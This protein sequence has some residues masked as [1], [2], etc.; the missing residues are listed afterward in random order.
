MPQHKPP[1]WLTGSLK[2]P[3]LIRKNLCLPCLFLFF[4]P[5]LA[6]LWEW[7]GEGDGWGVGPWGARSV[8]PPSICMLNNP[9]TD[10]LEGGRLLGNRPNTLTHL[11]PGP[12]SMS[13]GQN[14]P[15]DPPLE[16]G[17][18]KRKTYSCCTWNMTL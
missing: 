12:Q 11:L 13:R 9:Q 8:R 15:S 2:S 16:S 10:N 4:Q 14:I 7:E 6:L 18:K 3:I 1:R 5:W 17:L